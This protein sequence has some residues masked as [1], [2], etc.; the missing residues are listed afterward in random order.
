M[1]ALGWQ[2]SDAW[3]E[4]EAQQGGDGE[5]MVGEAASV[6]I[7]LPDFLA[8]VGHQQS[9]QNVGRFV[10][11]GRDGLGGEGSELVGDMGVGL[12][13][14]FMAVFGVDEVHRFALAGGGEELPVA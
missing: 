12:Q 14:G 6:G 11:R 13:P 3:D 2:V 7:L 4:L 9:V 5:D 1:K 8:S 10:H